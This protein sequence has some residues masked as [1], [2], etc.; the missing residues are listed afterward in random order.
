[1]SNLRIKLDA[2]TSQV[3][4]NHQIRELTSDDLQGQVGQPFGNQARIS[5]D[6]G[7]TW[8][9]PL[10]I[11][12]DGEG[13]DLGYPATVELADGALLT[14]WYEFQK[15]AGKAVLRQAKWKVGK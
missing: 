7:R 9:E 2:I 5:S 14:V 10:T 13:Y 6:Q 8:S 11:S 4:G 12:A 1:V 15:A 3:F